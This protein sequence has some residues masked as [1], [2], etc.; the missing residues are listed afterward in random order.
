L[1]LNADG[2]FGVIKNILLANFLQMLEIKIYLLQKNL[3]I[4]VVG[5]G[6]FPLCISLSL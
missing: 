3:I 1:S 5:G 6:G 2:F 4:I